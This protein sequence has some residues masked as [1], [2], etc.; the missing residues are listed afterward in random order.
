MLRA[1]PGSRS[2]ND[3]EKPATVR[4]CTFGC[5]CGADGSHVAAAPAAVHK[6]FCCTR[7]VALFPSPNL[8]KR[9]HVYMGSPA[10]V[11]HKYA[12]C[13]W[14]C[15]PLCGT[16]CASVLPSRQ[17]LGRAWVSSHR[18]C[19]HRTDRRASCPVLWQVNLDG[20]RSSLPKT[21]HPLALQSARITPPS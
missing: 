21:P 3:P 16:V 5:S 11:A 19:L 2:Q 8:R 20:G 17:L 7:S 18:G 1:R 13:L 14:S 15:A 6:G 9:A 10:R 12:A 4:S